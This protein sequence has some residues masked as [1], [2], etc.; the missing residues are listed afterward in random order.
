LFGN[1]RLG[2]RVGAF[3]NR[4]TRHDAHCLSDLDATDKGSSRE[5]F[6]DDI[7]FER[8]IMIRTE[9]FRTT[10]GIA[11]HRRSI[12]SRH[13]ATRRDILREDATGCFVKWNPF[14]F[15][16]GSPLVDPVDQ[17]GHLGAC[18]KPTHA[19]IGAESRSHRSISEFDD[20][21][22]SGGNYP[23]LSSSYA[24]SRHAPSII[25]A[26]IGGLRH[27][28][29]PEHLA[30]SSNADGNLEEFREFAQEMIVAVM[31]VALP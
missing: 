22:D 27:A 31:A 5:G 11:V 8:R 26:R 3:W 13:R 23:R 28:T 9:R 6:A 1:F 17:L 16:R 14:H 7:E 25:P 30:H 29:F 19:H 2:D 21:A 12:E 4:R 20:C 18:S 10:Q 15:E 24:V